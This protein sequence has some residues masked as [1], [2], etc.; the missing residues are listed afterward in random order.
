MGECNNETSIPEV[1]EAS[2]ECCDIIETKCVTTS[3]ANSTF[4]YGK[5]ITLDKV[6]T[7]IADYVKGLLKRVKDNEESLSEINTKLSSG[8]TGTFE[9]VDG[10]Q[11]VVTEGIITE[12]NDL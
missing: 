8:V 7:R 2:L 3:E 6:F 1:D 11:V 9:T 10:K 4:L 5:G 12:I